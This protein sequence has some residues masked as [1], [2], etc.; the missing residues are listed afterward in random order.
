MD[1]QQLGLP[2]KQQAPTSFPRPATPCSARAPVATPPAELETRMIP[3]LPSYAAGRWFTAD[4]GGVTV[5][6]AVTGEAVTA[7]S[8]TGQKC[9]AIRRA[10]VPQPHVETMGTGTAYVFAAAWCEVTLVEPRSAQAA[11]AHEAIVN[12]ASSAHPAP[13]RE[14]GRWSG[15][16]HRVGAGTAGAQAAGAFV[17]SIEGEYRNHIRGSSPR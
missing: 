12:G 13:R 5:A 2:A 16:R 6:D 11:K 8:S 3:M 1:Q 4:D 14:L 17:S 9:T 7:V 15:P 10:L